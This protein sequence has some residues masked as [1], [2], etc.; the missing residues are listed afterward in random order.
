MSILEAIF[1]GLIHGITEIVPVGSSGHI[2]LFNEIFKNSEMELYYDIMLHLATLIAVMVAFREDLINMV[3]EFG[4]MFKRIFA[5]FLVFLAKKKGDTRH[6]YV[7]VIDT[8]YKKLLIMVLISLVPTAILGVLGQGITALC[9]STLW[10]VGI[11]FV[12]NGVMLFLV[13]RH[14][15]SLDR[16]KDVPY[17]SGILVGMAQGVSVVPGIS[18]TASTISMGI[19]LGFNKKLAVKYS[20]IMSIPAIVGQIVYK[21]INVDGK[22]ITMSLLPGYI[23]GMIIS[24]VA[25]FFAIRIMLKIVMRRKYLGFAIYCAVIGVVAILISLITK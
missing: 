10:A 6:T 4:D 3:F 15:E 18:R 25:G 14:K 19:F 20:F 21:L 24:G 1:L 7:N 9:A 13:D 8:S 12:L 2:V 5:N 23:I 16:V 17:S 22:G 11:C